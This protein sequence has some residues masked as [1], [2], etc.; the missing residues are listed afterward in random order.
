MIN[1]LEGIPD[2]DMREFLVKWRGKITRDVGAETVH[3]AHRDEAKR[4]YE[5]EHPYREVTD[6]LE[7]L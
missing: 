7:A 3:A 5:R 4:G 6:V 1:P 2:G